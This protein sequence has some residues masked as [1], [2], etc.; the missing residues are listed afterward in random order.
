MGLRVVAVVLVLAACRDTTSTRLDAAADG[1]A[2][3]APR[4]DGPGIDAS[5]A[6]V[7]EVCVTS[8]AA[9]EACMAFPTCVMECVEDV[10]Q[11]QCTAQELDAIEACATASCATILDCITAVPCLMP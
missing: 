11:A 9:L 1:S 7:M 8:C 3:D 5:P 2:I 10:D 6:R 4:G